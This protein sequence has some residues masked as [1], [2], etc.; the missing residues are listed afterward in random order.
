MSNYR[1][2]LYIFLLLT[3]FLS[4]KG[5]RFALNEAR[6]IS[7]KLWGSAKNVELL[8]A[9]KKG[10][11]SIKKVIVYKAML[12]EILIE[13]A[14]SV[15]EYALV[16]AMSANKGLNIRVN[17]YSHSLYFFVL[18]VKRKDEENERAVGIFLSSS[19]NK[20]N[21]CIGIGPCY[22][23]DITLDVATLTNSIF[24]TRH[25]LKIKKDFTLAKK[26][27][28]S[29]SNIRFYADNPLKPAHGDTSSYPENDF[30]LIQIIQGDNNKISGKGK[31]L[32]FHFDDIFK[33]PKA[34][35]FSY[36]TTIN[37]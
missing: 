26:A 24:L 5:P 32:V 3:A 12:K 25:S 36:D 35:T 2:I 8:A 6:D 16:D 34:L 17:G 1:S 4:C 21:K 23:G 10:I 13:N 18:Y 14:N 11:D 37:Y 31:R 30:Q 20:D 22:I 28:S 15:T 9:D 29:D 19:F 33:D 27:K 7:P